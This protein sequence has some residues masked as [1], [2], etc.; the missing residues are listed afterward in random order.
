MRLSRVSGILF[1][2]LPIVAWAEGTGRS[3]SV[4]VC[5]SPVLIEM[6]HWSPFDSLHSA[7]IE[8]LCLRDSPREGEFILR[9][10]V[11]FFSAF[12]TY[13]YHAGSGRVA[14]VVNDR[15]YDPP[16]RMNDKSRVR[17]A[18]LLRALEGAGLREVW[19]EMDADCHPDVTAIVEFGSIL[20]FYDRS[21]YYVRRGPRAQAQ[22]CVTQ[23]A[24][25]YRNVME[26]LQELHAVAPASWRRVGALYA[27]ERT[28][29]TGLDVS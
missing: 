6:N 26:V 13:E 9:L 4:P 3:S 24:Q 7:E 29:G 23:Y 22:G 14:I 17:P 11:T 19:S 1:C 27:F 8:P 21:G 20:E 10:T 28:D 25:V 2:I 12:G 15:T 16:I 5:E 18:A